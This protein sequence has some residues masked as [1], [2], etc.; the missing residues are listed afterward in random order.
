MDYGVLQIYGFWVQTP[1]E[2]TWW[3]KK[4]M[5]YDRLWVMTGMGYYRF[6]CNSTSTLHLYHDFRSIGPGGSEISSK[7]H[8]LELSAGSPEPD[9]GGGC[10]RAIA[11]NGG[12]F[13]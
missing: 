9:L 4:P 7:P 12:D 11:G 2:P 13:T 8:S 6:D 10:L 3:T 5:G 1:C